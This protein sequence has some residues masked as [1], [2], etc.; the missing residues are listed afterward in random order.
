MKTTAICAL[1]L[2]GI[3]AVG[4]CGGAGALPYKPKDCHMESG[5]AVRHQNHNLPP[6]AAYQPS[7][8]A[9]NQADRP[10]C[11]PL[12]AEDESVVPTEKKGL[13]LVTRCSDGSAR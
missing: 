8:G 2:A 3:F 11:S 4:F 6:A 10:G 13:R 9:N 7:A 1:A 12:R 5:G